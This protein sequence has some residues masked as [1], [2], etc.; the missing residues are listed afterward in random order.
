MKK[1]LILIGT[2]IVLILIVTFG[3]SVALLSRAFQGEKL[4]SI[5]V[6]D[7]TF[8]YTEITGIGN[9][10]NIN[11]AEPISDQDGKV[12]DQ[13]FD[14]KINANLVGSDM[15]Y[16]V[17]IEPTAD[18]TINLDGVKVY[19]TTVENNVEKDIQSN[20]DGLGKVKTISDY[21][22]RIIYQERILKNTKNYEKNF[23]VRI[24]IDEDT[25]IYTDEYMGT[26]GAFRINVNARSNQTMIDST[27]PVPTITGGTGTTWTT[28]SQTISLVPT[29][30]AIGGVTYEYYVTD[31]STDVPNDLT[32]ATGTTDDLYNVI[33]VGQNYIYYRTVSANNK[34]AWSEP[35]I[36]YYD[37][38]EYT[39]TYNLDGGIQGEDAVTSY[40]VET[41]TFNLPT[42]TKTGYNFEGWYE[43]SNFNGES[44]TQIATGTRGNKTYYAKF[45]PDNVLDFYSSTRGYPGNRNSA[46]TVKRTWSANTYV[47]GMSTDNY[48]VEGTSRVS[49]FSITSTRITVTSGCGYGL[50]F[51]LL[52]NSNVTYKFTQD[53]TSTASSS[54]VFYASDGT[55]LGAQSLSNGVFTVP[56]NAYWTLYH[57]HGGGDCSG[58]GNATKYVD[59]PKIF[60]IS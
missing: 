57:V 59:N 2:I 32:I 54:V 49:N 39:I 1:K 31:D 5:T 21:T 36:V 4:T 56:S 12:L 24:W 30:P 22:N 11:D 47:S 6:G 16:E 41:P 7:L 8:K 48:Y 42:P 44:V 51:V 43:D 34:S 40:N 9:G 27:I 45:V 50:A 10:I 15:I 29:T 20:Y 53:S 35:Q 55:Y 23:R 17:S 33:R 28:N 38:T 60:P 13:Y 26:R 19:I 52:L 18:T 46:N 58:N 25:D 3:A 14:F 37:N